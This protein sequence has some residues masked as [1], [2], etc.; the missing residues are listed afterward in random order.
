MMAI[1]PH[2]G[3]LLACVL[4]GAD[5][6]L[7]PVS[8]RVL[9]DWAATVVG[10]A[11]RPHAVH[12]DACR[13]VLPHAI[14]Q[15]NLPVVLLPQVLPDAFR[16]DLVEQAGA[17]GE[18]ALRLRLVDQLVTAGHRA[19][20]VVGV[21]PLALVQTTPGVRGS[22]QV[23][24]VADALVHCEADVRQPPQLLLRGQLVDA[25]LCALDVHRVVRG[26]ALEVSHALV[27]DL[28]LRIADHVGLH[29]AQPGA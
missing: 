14:A 25:T 5:L 22:A 19:R 28:L 8:L 2:E 27:K 6:P 9:S 4:V 17:F 11:V 23:R 20:N 18:V 3:R 1:Q 15:P 16:P 26:Q 24:R 7:G 13:L 21:T 29:A 12:A 10:R